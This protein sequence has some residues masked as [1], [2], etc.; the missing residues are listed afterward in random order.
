MKQLYSDLWQTSLYSSGMLNSY[1]YLLQLPIG[2]VLIYNTNDESDLVHIEKLGGIKF[3]LLTHRD[4]AGKNLPRIQQRFSSKLVMSELEAKAVN[5]SH[6]VNQVF[7]P[8]DHNFYEIQVF[9]TPGH[10]DG[11]VCFLYKSPNGKTYLFTRDTFFIWNSSWSTL[12]LDNAGGDKEKLVK[13]LQKL[14]ELT[15]DVV[16]SSG[17]VGNVGYLEVNK[18]SWNHAID[19]EI[20]KLMK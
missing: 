10:T 6:E 16:M 5:K 15:P 2:N 11:S 14:R 20:S 19:T 7:N 3:Q 4:E 18:E 12:I 8:N 17:F 13:S 9:H 1:A